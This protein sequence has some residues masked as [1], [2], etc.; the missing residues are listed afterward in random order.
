[1]AGWFVRL[2]CAANS[3]IDSWK[4]LLAANFPDFQ[5]RTKVTK[6]MMAKVIGNRKRGFSLVEV[7]VAVAILLVGVVAALYIFPPGFASFK[8]SQDDDVASKLVQKYA[9]DLLKNPDSVPDAIMPVDTSYSLPNNEVGTFFSDINAVDYINNAAPIPA[10]TSRYNWLQKHMLKTPSAQWPLWQPQAARVMRWVVGEKIKVPAETVSV[11]STSGEFFVQK[12]TPVFSPLVPNA[13]WDSLNNKYSAEP[14]TIYDLRYT[15][16]DTSDLLDSGKLNYMIDY[17]TGVVTFASESFDRKIRI[18]FLVMSGTTIRQY[19]VGDGT[20]SPAVATV[21]AG[22]TTL[23]LKTLPGYIAGSVIIPGSEQFNRAYT[24]VSFKDYRT[25]PT[26]LTSGKYTFEPP[27]PQTNLLFGNIYFSRSDT[28]KSVKMDYQVAD[29]GILHEDVTVNNNGY[30]KLAVQNPK[31]AGK[32]NYPREPAPWGLFT[33]LNLAATNSASV[34]QNNTV[35]A[36]VDMQ[37]GQAY[38]IVYD[39]NHFVEDYN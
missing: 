18:T 30:L 36:M 28:G 34:V 4:I 25:T 32:P 3:K 39:P 37:T 1:M 11:T 23:N 33:P 20:I 38:E 29:W 15:R 31:I 17:S 22:T 9:D 24:Y 16:V 13:D 10:A 5:R 14:V 35:M 6:M 27:D 26:I 7:L 21:I 2:S 19:P 8:K 12:Y